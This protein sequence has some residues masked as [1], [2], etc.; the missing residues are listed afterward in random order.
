MDF[1]Q[2]TIRQAIAVN[3]IGVHFLEKNRYLEAIETFVD[4]ISLCIPSSSIYIQSCNDPKFETENVIGV[5]STHEMNVCD[6]KDFRTF[7]QQASNEKY[8][9]ALQRISDSK[10]RKNAIDSSINS[11]SNIYQNIE[12][13][14]ISRESKMKNENLSFCLSFEASIRSNTLY[15]IS[16]EDTEICSVD[17]ES[18]HKNEFKLERAIMLYNLGVSYFYASR[19]EL[20]E[21]SSSCSPS[22]YVVAKT[23][24]IVP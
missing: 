2:H 7:S 16:I 10:R 5:D 22:I 17:Y 24:C 14:R 9:I 1:S 18:N 4:A 13:I 8:H 3:N 11:R 21:K 19:N 23:A 12:V 6:L 20:C 15:P